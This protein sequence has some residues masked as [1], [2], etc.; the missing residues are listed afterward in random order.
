[1]PPSNTE[2]ARW[3]KDEVHPH[4]GQLKS[5]LRGQFP[6]VRDVDDVVQESYM[7]IWKA[8][9][10]HPIDSAKAFLFSV[11][12]RVALDLVRSQRR[13]PVDT[14]S[15]WETAGVL[16]TERDPAA[17]VSQQEKIDLLADAIAALPTRRR[18][19]VILRKL[20][21]LPQREVALRLDLSERTVENQ[22]YRG[23]RQCEEYLRIRGVRGLYDHEV[24]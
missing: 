13:S 22:L 20:Q 18:E 21:R 3:F 23:I 7:R 8:R 17:N 19:I 5:W 15:D 2:Q 4:D 16:S 10:A 14:V 11:A 12:R 6:T 9:L 1:M 24:R